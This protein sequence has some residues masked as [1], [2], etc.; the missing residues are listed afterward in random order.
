MKRRSLSVLL[1]AILSIPAAAFFIAM[2]QWQIEHPGDSSLILRTERHWLWRAP[3]HAHLD[4]GAI[5]I[6]V[7][8]ISVVAIALLMVALYQE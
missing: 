3:V 6:P 4:V 5:V 7:L 2:P 1:I 8:A